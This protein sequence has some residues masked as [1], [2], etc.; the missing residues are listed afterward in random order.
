MV[1]PAHLSWAMAPS[2]S[3]QSWLSTPITALISPAVFCYLMQENVLWGL[4]PLQEDSVLEVRT[5]SF[6][7]MISGQRPNTK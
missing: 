4:G 1:G 2:P 6:E 7:V 3:S 5:P